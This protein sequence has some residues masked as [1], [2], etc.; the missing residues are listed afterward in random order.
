MPNCCT[1]CF[2]ELPIKEFMEASDLH[3]NCDYCG[4]TD[5]PI[6]DVDE[7]G[8][9]VRAGALRYYEDAANQVMYVSADGGY[10]MSTHTMTEILLSDLDIFDS[11]H[12]DPGDLVDD[13]A[14]DDGT[15]VCKA[16]SIWTIARRARRD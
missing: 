15:G 6:H 4:S 8:E 13:L 14:D 16:R 9:F 12:F 2:S 11:S 3:G 10:Q 1:K 7:V 5:V